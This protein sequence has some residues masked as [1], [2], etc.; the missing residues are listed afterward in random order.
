MRRQR[1]DEEDQEQENKNHEVIVIDDDEES[2]QQKPIPTTTS[3]KTTVVSSPPE[4]NKNV[5]E[6]LNRLFDAL[7]EEK[8]ST[9]AKFQKPLFFEQ[10]V[11]NA[12]KEIAQHSIKVLLGQLIISQMKSHF[13]SFVAVGIKSQ[14]HLRIFEKYVK[15]LLSFLTPVTKPCHG[16]IVA[17]K[18]YSDSWTSSVVNSS[19]SHQ[20]NND[21]STE[22]NKSSLLTSSSLVIRRESVHQPQQ[23]SGEDQAEQQQQPSI[24]TVVDDDG[25]EFGELSIEKSIGIFLS[26]LS[27]NPIALQKRI[28][29]NKVLEK[30]IAVSVARWFGGILLGPVRFDHIRNC[31][32]A[33]LN[34]SLAKDGFYD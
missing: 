13:I 14:E 1:E 24:T 23:Q 18:C 16:F 20:E 34:E 31:S 19:S 26:S 2:N 4:V 17:S 8:S 32:N 25:E 6:V 10:R 30:G 3:L 22:N 29:R 5:M 15:T 27:R 11:K 12:E 9:T 7:K 28:T 33:V 21:T